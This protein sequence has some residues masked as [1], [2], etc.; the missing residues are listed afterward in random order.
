[1]SNVTFTAAWLLGTALMGIAVVA[2]PNL[3]RSGW[4][5]QPVERTVWM[6]VVQV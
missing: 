1:L 6:R 4:N 2:V 5:V 3:P